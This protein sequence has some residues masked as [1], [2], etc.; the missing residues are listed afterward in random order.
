MYFIIDSVTRPNQFSVLKPRIL[1]VWSEKPEV[2]CHWPNWRCGRGGTPAEARGRG[3]LPPFPAPRSA[4]FLGTP[5]PT[6][7]G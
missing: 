5:E 3:R 1:S 7:A 2:P 4:L 6:G